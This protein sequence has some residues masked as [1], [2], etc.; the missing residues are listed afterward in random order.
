MTRD[1]LLS[2]ADAIYDADSVVVLT[3]AG[4]STASGI[5]DFRSENGIWSTYEPKAFHIDRFRAD[6]TGFWHDR[7]ELIEEMF[8]GGIEP[9]VAH[10]ALSE[11]ESAG[12]LATLITQNID[13]LHETAG[14]DDVIEVHGN[15]QRVA[16]TGCGHRFGID[17]VMS[18]IRRDGD[19][20]PT[21]ERCGDVLK[22][23]V[24]LFGERLPESA[25]SH[26]RSAAR[27][28]DVFLAVG[29]SLSVEPAAS[30]P[31][32]ADDRGGALCVINLD[33]TDIS[34]RADYEFRED[35]TE[36]LPRLVDAVIDR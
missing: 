21:C 34:E 26:A 6:P 8:G 27:N 5:P 36:V 28:A 25:L 1:E 11:L 15:G 4:V 16:C 20:P 35:V 7:V 32:I 29:S 23:D 10:E 33:R 17:L 2:L 13:G 30:L 19:V 18:R 3:G 12:H 14:S 9:N 31:R 24:V 22:P